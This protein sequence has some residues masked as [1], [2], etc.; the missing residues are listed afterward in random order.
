MDINLDFYIHIDRQIDITY[1]ILYIFQEKL[2]PEQ[3]VP[4]T[5]Y[6]MPLLCEK[7]PVNQIFSAE[8]SIQTL[9]RL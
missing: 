2:L 3:Q 1:Y 5:N 6:D 9:K 4:N 7:D 8:E